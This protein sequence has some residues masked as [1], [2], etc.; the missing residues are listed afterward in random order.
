MKTLAKLLKNIQ[1]AIRED[2]HIRE[3]TPN[4]ERYHD[5]DLKSPISQVRTEIIADWITSKSSVLDVGC[6]EGHVMEYLQQ[7]K[8]CSVLGID[9]SHKAIEKLREKKLKGIVRDIDNEGLGLGDNELFD[10]ILFIEV[11]EHLKWPQNILLEACR[12]TKKGVIVAIP[13]SGY[14]Y[15]RWQLLK[16]YFPRQS[17]THL[18]YWTINDFQIFLRQLH[19]KPIGF[20]SE[21]PTKGI[22]GKIS[23]YLSNLLAY[24]QCW[25]I[26]PRAC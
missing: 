14:F 20:K 15:W 25:K 3:I 12:H 23:K 11:L 5:V 2:Y 17:F 9:I 22:K 16:G 1:K 10:F 13:N 26:A 8:D 7:K 4:Y 19:L 18:H 24:Q 6:G 21:L